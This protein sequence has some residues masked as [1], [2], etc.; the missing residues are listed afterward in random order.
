MKK[1][2]IFLFILS[3][4]LKAEVTT[5]SPFGVYL[6]YDKKS[7]KNSGVISGVYFS[8]G[9][10]S[11]LTEIS[12]SHTDI[13]YKYLTQHLTQDEV[14]FVYS[15]YF[16]NYAYKIGVHTNATTD[17]DLQNGTTAILGLNGWKFFNRAKLSYGVDFYNTYYPNGKDLND[18]N[19]SININELSF[20]VAYF[21]PFVSFSNFI[22]LTFNYERAYDIDFF[23][24]QLKDIIY[25]KSLSIE[26]SYFIGDLQTG[27]LDGGFSV[28]NS[29]DMLHHKANLKV[30]YNISYKTKLSLAYSKTVYDEFNNQ[31][32]LLKDTIY[33]S[34]SYIF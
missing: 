29:K 10:L 13:K 30:T 3:F 31:N 21:K 16:L 14:T 2:L 33:F 15:R 24:T 11:Y 28:Y 5:V 32:N 27:I 23:S 1:V 17:K 18:N 20:N 8:S 4:I 7:F 34:F 26:G 19:K 12:Y 9:T 6:D 25:F 22:S